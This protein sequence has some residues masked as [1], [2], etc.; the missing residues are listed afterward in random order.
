M[1]EVYK[2]DQG[3]I[4]IGIG[5]DTNIKSYSFKV[6]AISP[7]NEEQMSELLEVSTD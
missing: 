2:G 7:S 5:H 6:K 1:K 4:I 3:A